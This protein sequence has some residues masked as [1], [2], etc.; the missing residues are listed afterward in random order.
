MVALAV[1]AFLPSVRAEKVVV[2]YWE[3]WTGIEGEAMQR[4]VADFNA[5][6][7]RIEVRYSMISQIEMKLMLAIA[8][9]HPPDVAGIWSYSLP[10][11]VENNALRPLDGL[12]KSAGIAEEDYLPSIWKMCVYRGRLWALPSTPASVAL[13]WNK[14]LFREAGLDP[15]QPPRTIAE[16]EEFNEKLTKKDAQGNY[17]AFGHLPL[18]PDWWTTTWG[19]WFGATLWDGEDTLTPD[20]PENIRAGKWIA[21]YPKRFGVR[22]VSAF[23]EGMGSFASPLNPFIRGQVAME[24]QGPWM[25]NFLRKYGT[26]DF[27]LGV[28]PFP[29]EDGKGPPVTLVEADVLVIPKGAR[30]VQ[31]AW[32]FIRYVNQRGP[33]E[34]LCMGQCKFSPLSEVSVEFWRDHPHPDIRVFYDLA[35]SPGARPAPRVTVWTQY[36]AELDQAVKEVWALRQTPE[37]AFR[38]VRERMQPKLDQ[39]RK[40]WQQISGTLEKQW[41]EEDK[42]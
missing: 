23:L 27:E 21:S 28:A 26:G 34:K 20:S 31:E 25:W 37:E 38:K 24:I 32:E 35:A 15:E 18:E 40:R 42:P 33:M 1:L 8:G 29:S 2:E 10:V 39:R 6:Q 3:K 11:Y 7:D 19:F 9:R 16:L 12:A 41:D 17:V 5:S 14:R 36:K 13:H 4:V 22:P 30:H